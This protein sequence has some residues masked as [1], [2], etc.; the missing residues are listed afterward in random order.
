MLQQPDIGDPLGLRDR[1]ILEVLYSTGMRRMEV[2]RL[3][4]YDVDIDGGTVLD[5]SGQRQERPHRPDR[6]A[7][8]GMDGEV[9][10]MKPVRSS[11]SEPDDCTMFLTQRGRADQLA[12]I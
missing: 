6:R 12:Y 10:A 4:L 2:A 3:K 1:A 9:H 11:S 8:R 5:P 7:G